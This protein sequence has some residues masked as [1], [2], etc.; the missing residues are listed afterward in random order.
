MPQ[1]WSP[2]LLRVEEWLPVI[3]FDANY[4]VSFFYLLLLHRIFPGYFDYSLPSACTEI[5]ALMA[6]VL[7]SFKVSFSDQP[8]GIMLA[9]LMS[10][11]SRRHCSS[12]DPP[13]WERDLEQQIMVRVFALLASYVGDK[14]ES[15]EMFSKCQQW[16]HQSLAYLCSDLIL[17]QSPVWLY[18]HFN[19]KLPHEWSLP[20]TFNTCQI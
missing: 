6:L 13:P 8:C 16:Y 4:K 9:S 3:Y 10:I 11:G 17:I 18:V 15:L 19:F 1:W 12:S 7:F 14:M 20:I 2:A 5:W